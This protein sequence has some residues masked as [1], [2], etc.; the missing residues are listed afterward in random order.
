MTRLLLIS[1]CFFSFYYHSQSQIVSGQVLDVERVPIPNVTVMVRGTE[2]G[3]QTDIEGYYTLSNVQENA[4][5]EFLFLGYSTQSL[6]VLGRSN[7]NI[8]LGGDAEAY[9]SKGEFSGRFEFIENNELDFL[10]SNVDLLNNFLEVEYRNNYTK[11]FSQ[12]YIQNLNEFKNNPEQLDNLKQDFELG[13]F[14][15]Y[16]V[17]NNDD[18]SN[19]LNGNCIY[20]NSECKN[21]NK[22]YYNYLGTRDNI[23][24]SF[25]NNGFGT[26]V[27]FQ[28]SRDG[29][30]SD[31]PVA[32]ILITTIQE[33]IENANNTLVN[34]NSPII[35]SITISST[36]NGKHK[37]CKSNHYGGTAIDINK[38]NGI[39]ISSRNLDN[40]IV[41]ELQ[42]M[43]KE[44]QYTRE[45]YGPFI[46]EKYFAQGD[47]RIIEDKSN[48]TSLVRSHKGH[49]H[50]AVR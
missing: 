48:K 34:R 32:D 50:L 37:G 5:L 33:A 15:E 7:V 17:E 31:N 35:R 44:G 29:A 43:L 10:F 28:N 26:L 11:S 8:V 2:N 36:T 47:K 49:I 30:T 19:W 4:V 16:T 9:L 14:E 20:K 13:Y 3:T 39:K 22:C 42:L 40:S 1:I 12:I 24:Q 45:N 21:Q 6:P 18:L 27:K 23:T 38:I 41:Q 46:V 25:K